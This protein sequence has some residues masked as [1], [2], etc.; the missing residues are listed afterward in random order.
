MD[1]VLRIQW[2]SSVVSLSHRSGFSF[3]LI[4]CVRESSHVNGQCRREIG[5]LLIL[6]YGRLRTKLR[7]GH[8]L[9]WKAFIQEM[10]QVE[11]IKEGPHWSDHALFTLNKL[12]IIQGY[13]VNRL[14]CCW[15]LTN[16]NQF[17][18]TNLLQMEILLFHSLRRSHCIVGLSSTWWV[19]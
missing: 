2:S 14:M 8:N 15:I 16:Q 13:E 11:L 7:P 1:G 19:Y 3:D 18:F 9:V 4:I 10:N 12:I 5:T 6:S 17:N